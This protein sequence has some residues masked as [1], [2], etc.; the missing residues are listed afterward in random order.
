MLCRKNSPSPPLILIYSIYLVYSFSFLTV[1]FS[2][3]TMAMPARSWTTK[4]SQSGLFSVATAM[5]R[6][7]FVSHGAWFES[8]AM[9]WNLPWALLQNSEHIL[10]QTF[11]PLSYVLSEVRLQVFNGHRCQNKNQWNQWAN[12]QSFHLKNEETAFLNPA[13]WLAARIKLC[14]IVQILICLGLFGLSAFTCRLPLLYS[15]IIS[16][17]LSTIERTQRLDKTTARCWPESEAGVRRQGNRTKKTISNKS[18][19]PRCITYSRTSMQ[20]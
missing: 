1:L 5:S 19:T 9:W 13:K 11:S 14:K 3:R 2:Q 10:H 4:L 12:I 18:D 15:P 7:L 6:R 17:K 20:R 16:S 8:T